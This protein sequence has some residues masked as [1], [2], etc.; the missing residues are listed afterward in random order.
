MKPRSPVIV[1]FLIIAG[2]SD[3]V[4]GAIDKTKA[5]EIAKQAVEQR[6]TWA[7]RATYDA[8]PKG[9][10]WTV[11]VLRIEGIDKDGKPQF[12]PG[13]TRYVSI[14][15]KGNVRDYSRGL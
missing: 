5:I 3:S 2:C 10:G 11:V 15:N 6:D 4:L 12:V 13:G 9:D 1:M 8:T 14:D 7:D